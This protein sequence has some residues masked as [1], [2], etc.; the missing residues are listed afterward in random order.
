M[1]NDVVNQCV[2]NVLD[3]CSLITHMENEHIKTE[4]VSQ[5][6]ILRL[7]DVISKLRPAECEIVNITMDLLRDAYLSS[8]SEY[9]KKTTQKGG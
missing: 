9:I 8:R 2:V 1:T 7:K 3:V 6:N 4:C 5:E